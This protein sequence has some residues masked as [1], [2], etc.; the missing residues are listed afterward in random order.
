MLS[1][2]EMREKIVNGLIAH[3]EGE[4]ALH[5]TNVEVYLA[6]TVGI[7]E[8]SDI[9][10]TVQKELDIIATQNDR[11]EILNKYFK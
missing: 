2:Q 5:K 8:H 3:A 1:D 6:K 11:L 9:L 4:I 7:G 10:E